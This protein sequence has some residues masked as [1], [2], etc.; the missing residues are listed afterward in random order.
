MNFDFLKAFGSKKIFLFV[1]TV[2]VWKKYNISLIFHIELQRGGKPTFNKF[3]RLSALSVQNRST[4][5][6][7]FVRALYFLFGSWQHTVGI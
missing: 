4:F 7:R 6:R 3:R 5:A 2:C 1:S